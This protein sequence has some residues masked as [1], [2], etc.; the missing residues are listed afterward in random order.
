M[1][2][3]AEFCPKNVFPSGKRPG[4]HRSVYIFLLFSLTVF[5]GFVNAQARDSVLQLREV[6]FEAQSKK[7][8]QGLKQ[9]HIDSVYLRENASF[10]LA[11][12]MA[13]QNIYI[14]TYD[15]GL[16]TVSMRGTSTS[17]TKMYWNDMPLNSPMLGLVDFNLVPV[18]LMDDVE[19]DYGGASL[20]HG[21]GG[22]GGSINL[23]SDKKPKEK[24]SIDAYQSAGSFGLYR[25]F[26]G[27]NY[28]TGK[29][30][31][32]TKIYYQQSKNDYP[33][34]N[35]SLPDEP[36][37]KLANAGWHEY[38]IMQ[39]FGA[40]LGKRTFLQGAA[41]FQYSNRNLPSPIV[42]PDNKENQVD[43]SWR[44]SLIMKHYTHTALWQAEANYTHEYLNY[45]NGLTGLNSQSYFDHYMAK[46]FTRYALSG[47]TTLLAGLQSIHDVAYVKDYQQPK[48]QDINGLFADLNSRFFERLGAG[49]MIR[50]EN[51]DLNTT[52]PAAIATLTYVVI[53]NDRLSLHANG[54]RNYNIPTLNELYW[55]PGGNPGL[56]PETSN[57]LEAG[58]DTRWAWGKDR[59][60]LQTGS[61]VFSNYIDGYILWSP[62]AGSNIWQSQNLKQVWARGV[63][64]S[65]IFAF[66]LG[67]N[68]LSA[69]ALYTYTHS[70]SQVAV[71]YNDNSVGKQLIYIPVN[72]ATGRLRW[73]R[74]NTSATLEYEYTDARNTIDAYLPPFALLHLAIAH[75]FHPKFGDAIL[76]L[77]VNN[78]TN[79][80][81]Q[82][83]EWRPMPGR[84]YELSIKIH[85]KKLS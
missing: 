39:N 49:I 36:R 28:G 69:Q 30:W 48:S 46:A 52:M 8:A 40:Q 62:S 33:Y 59:F 13:K 73:E 37:Q 77:R 24:F 29:I 54:G 26:L 12:L 72:T 84:W 6:Q 16:A 5:P 78:L 23:S 81:Y 60:C 74:R 32:S 9:V 57:L 53:K 42:V 51:I 44:N 71:G 18:F 19:V 58:A 38:G 11:D 82:A 2:R 27:L 43:G 61:T 25:G 63:E 3:A 75:S 47:K 17:H 15:A 55:I 67:K 79:I 4:R 14:K 80:S 34:Y 64:N 68:K 45:S 10:N 31:G 41:W 85:L 21:S 20:N 1:I 66:P 50:A 56:K 7:D 65:L 76:Q 83:I 70:T 22:F 35:T